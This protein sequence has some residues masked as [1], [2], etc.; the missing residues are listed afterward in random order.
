WLAEV[1]VQPLPQL[2]VGGIGVPRDRMRPLERRPLALVEAIRGRVSH[3]LV[4]L[5]YVARTQ[6][7]QRPVHDA[8]LEHCLARLGVGAQRI[9][10]AC[11]DGVARTH[12]LDPRAHPSTSC[13]SPAF[14]RSST[15]PWPI[16]SVLIQRCW[17]YVMAMK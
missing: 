9:R 14:V 12:R 6:L 17:P 10:D 3:N 13:A 1:G 7:L 8:T 5:G 16:P 15:S 11:A 2:L 4:V